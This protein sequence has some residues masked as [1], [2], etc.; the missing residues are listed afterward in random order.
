MSRTRRHAFTSLPIFDFCF[1]LLFSLTDSLS[2]ETFWNQTFKRWNIIWNIQKKEKHF[3]VFTYFDFCSCLNSPI[4]SNCLDNEQSPSLTIECPG[5]TIKLTKVICVKLSECA[6]YTP[7]SDDL[8]TGS[9]TTVEWKAICEW[10]NPCTISAS[11]S[12]SVPCPQFN[13]YIYADYECKYML[14]LL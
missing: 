10:T 2:F 14:G 6:D 3:H 9:D 5:M 4:V 12:P 7:A 1:N 13:S 8:C 11:C